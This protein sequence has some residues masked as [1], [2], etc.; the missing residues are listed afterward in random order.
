MITLNQENPMPAASTQGK[1]RTQADRKQQMILRLKQAVI[2]A[3]VEDGYGSSTIQKIATRA[4]VSQ[5][6]IFRHFPT[7]EDLIVATADTLS[8][9]MIDDYRSKAEK[10]SAAEIDV[11][12]LLKL[13]H[14]I[15]NSRF[16]YAWMELMI[17]VRTDANLKLR[18]KPI[19]KRNLKGNHDLARE[20]FPD[21]LSNHP[22]FTQTVDAVVMLFRGQIMDQFI[23]SKRELKQRHE[24]E[25]S[26]AKAL[27]S[28][29]FQL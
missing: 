27:I 12:H 23:F 5:G 19:F 8:E 21:S 28:L 25:A 3:L 15:I 22:E 1:K 18:L 7:R 11:D 17:A 10:Q 26:A 29:I 9:W 4:G 24:F 20:I 6:A 16:H 14:D 2:D 13:L